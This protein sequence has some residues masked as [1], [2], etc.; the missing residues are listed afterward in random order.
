MHS[1]YHD[2]QVPCAPC[3]VFLKVAEAVDVVPPSGRGGGDLGI[4]VFE[5]K[6]NYG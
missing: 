4:T 2:C 3:H 1:K 5:G 6:V